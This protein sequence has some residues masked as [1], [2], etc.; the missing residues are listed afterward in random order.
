[1]ILTGLQG[2]LTPVNQSLPRIWLAILSFF[3]LYVV[4][5]FVKI[6]VERWAIIHKKSFKSRECSF[7]WLGYEEVKHV[8]NDIR[9]KKKKSN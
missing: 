3:L 2:W 5:R 4:F 7:K 6:L 9:S 1:M 8:I